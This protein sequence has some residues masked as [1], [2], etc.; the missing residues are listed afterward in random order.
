MVG[1]FACARCDQLHEER[2]AAC[3]ECGHEG[4]EAL[5][6]SEFRRRRRAGEEPPTE[7]GGGRGRLRTAALAVLALGLVVIGLA[8]IGMGTMA[9]GLTIP[10]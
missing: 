1:G 9:M 4:M 10:F 8:A 6:F 7:P 5:T 3:H 2:P